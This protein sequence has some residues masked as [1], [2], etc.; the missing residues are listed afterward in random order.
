MGGGAPPPAWVERPLATGV[1]PNPA[2]IWSLPGPPPPPP[3]HAERATT[4]AVP[5]TKVLIL[6]ITMS[7]PTRSGR[8]NGRT[9]LLRGISALRENTSC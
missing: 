6:R 7:L 4:T 3:P 9:G 1:E 2:G 8:E 5:M